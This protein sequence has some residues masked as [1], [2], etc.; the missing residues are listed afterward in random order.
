MVVCDAAWKVLLTS[1]KGTDAAF[2]PKEATTLLPV[3]VGVQGSRSISA[4][5]DLQLGSDP[6]DP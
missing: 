2:L 1:I 5:A 4:V 6:T 3:Q